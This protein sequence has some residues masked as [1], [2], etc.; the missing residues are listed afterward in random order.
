MPVCL[1]FY[2]WQERMNTTQREGGKTHSNASYTQS[3]FANCDY[4]AREGGGHK[5]CC[6]RH[7]FD[8]SSSCR[9]REQNWRVKRVRVKCEETKQLTKVLSV[10]YICASVYTGVYTVELLNIPIFIY[11]CFLNPEVLEQVICIPPLNSMFLLDHYLHFRDNYSIRM[12]TDTHCFIFCQ[13]TIKSEAGSKNTDLAYIQLLV[14]LLCS[15]FVLDN[16]M[17]RI[18]KGRKSNNKNIV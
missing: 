10:T 18:K 11:R 1:T 5:N 4:L 16:G 2:L 7:L 17:K 14:W 15:C 6:L 13:S 9:R 3:V 8:P 12:S